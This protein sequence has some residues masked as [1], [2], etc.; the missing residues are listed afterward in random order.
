MNLFYFLSCFVQR[1]FLWKGEVEKQ[2][3]NADSWWKKNGKIVKHVRPCSTYLSPAMFNLYLLLRH[4][5]GRFFF[6]MVLRSTEQNNTLSWRNNI[7]VKNKFFSQCSMTVRMTNG[8]SFEF[9]AQNQPASTFSPVC[10]SF[11]THHY[12]T[13]AVRSHP[14]LRTFPNP[15]FRRCRSESKDFL[16]Q[17]WNV[18]CIS[19]C[20]LYSNQIFD[21]EIESVFAKSKKIWYEPESAE[22]KSLAIFWNIWKYLN[23]LFQ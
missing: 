2:P 22:K 1:L 18:L 9:P 21:L 19:R 15:F 16:N 4:T 13:C 7:L 23:L 20:T 3:E 8:Y 17:L 14:C 11:L 12:S 10:F 6:C 5:E